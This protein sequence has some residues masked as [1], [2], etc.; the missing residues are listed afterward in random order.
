MNLMPMR[1]LFQ[2]KHMLLSAETALEQEKRQR[3]EVET[4]QKAAPTIAPAKEEELNRRIRELTV[5]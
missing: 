5:I 1:M 2:V 4:K 3:L